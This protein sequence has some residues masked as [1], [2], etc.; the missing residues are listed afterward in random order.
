MRDV[1]D[2]MSLTQNQHYYSFTQQHLFDCLR[3]KFGSIIKTKLV[4]VC[5]LIIVDRKNKNKYKNKMQTNKIKNIN[6]ISLVLN[7]KFRKF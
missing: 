2:G 3:L 7:S 6:Y 1:N 4:P 5:M